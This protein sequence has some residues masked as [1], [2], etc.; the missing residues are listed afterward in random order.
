LASHED[1]WYDGMFISKG[2]VMMANVWLLNRD[3]EIYGADA[4]HFNPARF[5]DTN[6]DTAPCPSETKEA[7]HVRAV[8][9]GVSVRESTS[10]TTRSSS[11]LL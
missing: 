6:G 5:L 2:T 4:A 7:D 11:T 9:G 8:L 10:R 1:D 3:P